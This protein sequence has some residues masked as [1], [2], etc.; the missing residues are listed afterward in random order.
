MLT[1]QLV[2][3]GDTVTVVVRRWNS[4]SQAGTIPQPIQE[5][6]PT[7]VRLYRFA[8]GHV[9][10]ER[11]LDHHERLE[12]LF[13]A[14]IIEA[15]PDVVHVQ[16]LIGL[17][18]RFIEIAHRH[19]A[20]VVLSLHDFYFTCPLVQLRKTTGQLCA[21]PDGGRECAR[22]CFASE[23]EGARLRWGLRTAYFRRLLA[24]A[25]RIICPSTYLAAY[26]EQA[27]ADPDRVRVIPNGISIEPPT[28]TPAMWSTPVERG[29]LNLA[30][31]GTVVHHK[32]V[33]VILD[34]V[35]SANL[36]SVNLTVI[37]Q[38]LDPNYSRALR[39]R[40]AAIPGLELRLHGGYDPR[41]LPHLL[42]DVDCVIIPSQVPETFSL[43]TREALA[44]GIPIV[45]SR[46]GALPAA[47][48][49]GVNGFTFTHDR[50]EELADILTRLADDECLMH[51]LREGACQTPIVTASQHAQAVRAVYEE[52][53][54]DLARGGATRWG[55]LEELDF[56]HWALLKHGF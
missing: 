18:P 22:T 36:D 56:L 14:A 25:E 6:L 39:A 15:A 30:F 24:M 44:L 13:T 10:L 29:A 19:G 20:A 52:A 54:E 41:D 2:E 37:G 34:A 53:L 21:G 46:L 7:G 17:S 16:H 38:A 28:S 33:H 1:T 26:F 9:S 49:E 43:V 47:V 23:S 12:Q 42:D 55:D 50:P 48:T 27:G 8:G 11:F 32:G 45:V 51:R 35:A 31:L 4:A 40:A 3:L 5:E